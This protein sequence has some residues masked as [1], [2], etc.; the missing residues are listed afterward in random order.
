MIFIFGTRNV[1]TTKDQGTF[2]CPEC[3][4][5]RPYKHKRVRRFI[6]LYFLPVIPLDKLGEYVECQECGKRFDESVLGRAE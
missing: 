6:S 5:Y 1:G 3:Q 2:Y 4:G